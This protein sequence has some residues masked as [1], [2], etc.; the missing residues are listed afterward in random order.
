M[1]RPLIDH[2]FE[3]FRAAYTLGPWALSSG[4]RDV[5][6]LEMATSVSAVSSVE[7]SSLRDH[8]VFVGGRFGI[9]LQISNLYRKEDPLSSVSSVLPAE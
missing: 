7:K 2:L 5:D 4:R 3:H 8:N 1:I 6:A 9:H